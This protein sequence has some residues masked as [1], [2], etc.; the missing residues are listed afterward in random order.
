MLVIE[1]WDMPRNDSPEVGRPG[2]SDADY[3]AQCRRLSKGKH[4]ASL[5][6]SLVANCG[7]LYC[8]LLSRTQQSEKQINRQV[9][10]SIRLSVRRDRRFPDVDFVSR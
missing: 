2:M 1:W 8:G 3:K 7:M 6:A 4:V 9:L 10:G 5:P